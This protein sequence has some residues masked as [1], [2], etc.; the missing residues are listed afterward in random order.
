MDKKQK[1]T[2]ARRFRGLMPVVVDC[3]TGGV[4]FETDALL[5]LAAVVLAYRDGVLVPAETYHYHVQAFPGA[6]LDPRALEVT[7][8]KPDHPFRFAQTEQDVLID[9]HT[10][11]RSH[12]EANRCRKAV[13]VAQNAQ[14]DADFIRAAERRCGMQADSPWHRFTTFD[15]ATVGAVWLGEPVLARAVRKAGLFFDVNEAHSALYD[16]QITADFF[17]SIV[18]QVDQEQ[19]SKR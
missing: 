18:N 8:I 6:N 7:Q 14:F 2:I 19:S 10:H 12:L 13:I 3:E 15:T 9:L 11:L 16:A 17:C 4:N 1:K 5:E